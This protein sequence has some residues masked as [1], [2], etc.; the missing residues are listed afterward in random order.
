MNGLG[1]TTDRRT[2]GLQTLWVELIALG[3]VAEI[4]GGSVMTA[5]RG[6]LRRRSSWRSGP[7]F[8]SMEDAKSWVENESRLAELPELA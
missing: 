1:W 4:D 2:A 3:R 5:V 6:S 8:E 7:T